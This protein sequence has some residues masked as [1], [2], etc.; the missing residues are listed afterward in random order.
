MSLHQ[1]VG[2]AERGSDGASGCGAVGTVR[3]GARVRRARHGSP[4]VAIPA[5]WGAPGGVIV[6]QFGGRGA[7]AARP[8]AAVA[9]P[10]S[11]LVRPGGLGDAATCPEQRPG[12]PRPAGAQFLGGG[13]EVLL[14]HV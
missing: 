2:T 9:H 8:W 14:A 3:P 5:G 4:F 10:S 11:L 1:R 6:L 13:V 7:E 12:E